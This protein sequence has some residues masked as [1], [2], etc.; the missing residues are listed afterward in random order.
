MVSS[1]YEQFR[2]ELQA[3]HT[4]LVTS[5]LSAVGDFV[6]LA[7]VPAGIAKRSV[8]VSAGVFVL[9]YVIAAFAHLFQPGTVK[10]ELTAVGRHPIWSARAESA[11][12][13][14]ILRSRTI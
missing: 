3:R 8:K 13:G 11:R 4:N 14:G 5:G 6:L 9:G 2:D 1:S 12:V 7:A 10:D